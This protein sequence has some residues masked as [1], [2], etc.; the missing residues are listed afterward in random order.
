MI[1]LGTV[2][3]LR[4]WEKGAGTENTVGVDEESQVWGGRWK[5][6]SESESVVLD[7][8]LKLEEGS[9]GNWGAMRAMA[10]LIRDRRR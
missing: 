2:R 9:G 6:G 7:R 8:R 1:K 10:G 5:G 3:R 4:R